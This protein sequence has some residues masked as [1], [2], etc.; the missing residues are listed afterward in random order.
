MIL[1]ILMSKLYVSPI[2][3]NKLEKKK[4][5]YVSENGS[6]RFPIVSSVPRFCKIKNYT[7]SFGYQWNKYDDTQLDSKNNIKY[8]YDRFY[9]ATNWKPDMIAKQKI[10]AVQ[11]C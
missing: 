1:I 2:T 10:L 11:D 3:G 9:T 8:S 4:D 6:E 7:E 5:Y